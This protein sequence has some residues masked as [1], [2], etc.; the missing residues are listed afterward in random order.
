[1]NKSTN[2]SNQELF[3]HFKLL[4]YYYKITCEEFRSKT[5]EKVS[6]EI[7]KILYEIV[8]SD[9]VVGIKGFG[10]STISEIDE[11]F[12]N[13]E[14]NGVGTTKRLEE[15]H[16]RVLARK[17]DKNFKK[18]LSEFTSYYGIG[19]NYA[20]K[21][22]LE[23]YRDIETLY[24]SGLLTEPQKR[25]IE[26]KEHFDLIIEE[27]EMDEIKKLFKSVLNKIEFSFVGPY[28]QGEQS[29]D[30]SV[31][32]K[33]SKRDNIT[34]ED[35]T[36]MITNKVETL[37][38]LSK[39]DYTF[40]GILKLNENRNGHKIIIRITDEDSYP[41]AL[42]HFTGPRKFIVAMRRYARSKD[43]E[44]NEHGLFLD[45][46]N[47]VELGSEADIF[48]VLQLGYLEPNERNNDENIEEILNKI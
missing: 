42:L 1:M 43:M 2:L 24:F 23:G 27:E 44:L 5:F 8:S 41:T 10:K 35:I 6:E 30:I 9:D 17:G 36:S 12:T 21:F 13:K 25:A 29:N 11:F 31:L 19:I 45:S 20:V 46:E 33:K 37:I 14:I 32:I 40:V 26:W 38:E 16:E 47:Y 48:E 39:E 7:S 3:E 4:S 22:Y 34:M 18:V 28:R 15:L